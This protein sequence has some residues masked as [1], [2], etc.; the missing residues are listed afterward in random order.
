MAN[1]LAD[2]F[3]NTANAIREK[4]GDTGTMK[5]AEFPEKIRAIEAGGGGGAAN[6]VSLLAKENG[7][8]LPFE[9]IEIGKSYSLKSTFTQEK[10]LEVYNLSETRT[11]INDFTNASLLYSNSD[12]TMFAALCFTLGG[13]SCYGLMIECDVPKAWFPIEVVTAMGLGS[14]DG[15]YETTDMINYTPISTSPNFT[16]S[17]DG[18]AFVSSVSD[19]SSLFN[20]PSADGFS[21]V[22]VDVK[23]SGSV[24]DAV[25]WT[26]TFVGADGNTLHQKLC[27]DGDDCYDPVITGKIGT[28]TKESTPQYTFTHNGW[29]LTDGGA[30][31]GNALSAVT[32]DRTVYA[33]FKEN[34]RYYTVRFYDGTTL[35]KTESVAYGSKATPPDTNKGGGYMFRGWTPSDLTITSNTD[36]Y[37]TWEE[38]KKLEAYTWAEIAAIAESGEAANTFVIGDTKDVEFTL[39]GTTVIKHTVQ[40]AAFNHDNL[41][42]GGKAG[43]T[44]LS[45]KPLSTVA[46]KA[47]NSSSNYECWTTLGMLKG[48]VQ[49]IFLGAYKNDELFSLV[50]TVDKLSV[51]HTSSSQKTDI[52]SQEKVWIPSVDELG[53]YYDFNDTA[54][55]ELFTVD[56]EARKIGYDYWL[57]DGYT[58]QSKLFVF[59]SSG[60]LTNKNIYATACIRWGFCI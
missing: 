17:G 45:T 37:G 50:K 13:A 30:A 57:R 7:T 5:P 60:S 6:L 54:V 42:S 14:S 46:V 11:P 44:F 36:F 1:V 39:S 25:V 21:S 34:V 20:T 48:E 51:K 10:L 3:Q 29:S 55:Y 15:W 8:Y 22:T 41:S 59:S 12:G 56:K 43:I 23:N 49:Q 53:N 38:S 4:T 33:A 9:D 31:D 24:E 58:S 16:F 26:V 2:L 19:L 40:I 47:G 18:S 28:P 32:S 27:L 52:L 35:M